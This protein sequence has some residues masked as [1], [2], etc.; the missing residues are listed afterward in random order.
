MRTQLLS[1]CAIFMAGCASAPVAE[2][3]PRAVDSAM[4]QT[5]EGFA[6]AAL[7]P[8]EDFNLRR[9]DIPDILARLDSP[10]GLPDPVNCILIRDEVIALT[11]VLGPDSDI[12][13]P[14]E[15]DPDHAQWVAD[16][17]SDAALDVIADQ[18]TGWIPF[19]GLLREAT[20]ANDHESRVRRAYTLG[21]QRRAYLKGV[22]QQLGCPW[23]A[24]PLG[25]IILPEGD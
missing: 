2:D 16:Q 20:G 21:H 23:P 1:L 5:R 19:R 8:L 6:E 9:E 4:Q 18:A 13:P 10:Y 22:G 25:R 17:S 7:S 24:A 11:A 15:D 3:A 12:P 14:D